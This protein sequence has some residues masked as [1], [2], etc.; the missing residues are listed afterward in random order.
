[1]G[2]SDVIKI[3]YNVVFIIS[4]SMLINFIAIV[5]NAFAQEEIKVKPLY[6]TTIIQV[7]AATDE[8][9]ISMTYAIKGQDVFVDCL[10]Q[11]VVLNEEKV[12]ATHQEGEGHYRLYIDDVHIETLFTKSFVIEGLDSGEHTVRTELVK[13]DKTRYGVEDSVTIMIP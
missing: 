1:M 7:V 3:F 11:Q 9:D 4:M 6:R 2:D 13:N 8:P 5:P 10:I 12:G